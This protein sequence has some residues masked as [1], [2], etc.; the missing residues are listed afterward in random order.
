MT[1]YVILTEHKQGKRAID[2]TGEN[3]WSHA[4]GA[5]SS[6]DK[7]RRFDSFEEAQPTVRRLREHSSA[8]FYAVPLPESYT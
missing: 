6:L 8:F 5:F 2:W 7:A 4:F 3:F 1:Q